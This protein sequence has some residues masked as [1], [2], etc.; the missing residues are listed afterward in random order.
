[1]SGGTLMALAADEVVMDANAVLGPVDPQIPAGFG[2]AYPAAS[3]VEALK[4]KNPNRDDRTLILGDVARK[5]IS[6]VEDAAYELLEPRLGKAKARRISGKLV[7]GGWTHDKP[8]TPALAK[9][10]GLPVSTD[11]PDD[12]HRLLE[13]YPQPTR[14]M[15]TVEY[16]PGTESEKPGGDEGKK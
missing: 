14:R 9:K 6:Q 4:K 8:I 12:F 7:H 13:L 5:A 11:L 2:L 15:A 3:I 16:I 1:M 10:M